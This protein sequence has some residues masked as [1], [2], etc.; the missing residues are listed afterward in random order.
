MTIKIIY[1]SNKKVNENNHEINNNLEEYHI[2]NII[3]NDQININNQNYN[4]EIK[5]DIE[6]DNDKVKVKVKA[7]IDNRLITNNEINLDYSNISYDRNSPE[8]TQEALI[9][10]KIKNK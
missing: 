5:A 7:I 6:E 1:M 9:F 10:Q 2:I 3:N 4:N 8:K